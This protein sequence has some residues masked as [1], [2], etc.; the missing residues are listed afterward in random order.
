MKCSVVRE[1]ARVLGCSISFLVED[2]RQLIEYI[3]IIQVYKRLKSDCI[4]KVAY[5]QLKILSKIEGDA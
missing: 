3:E 4:R 5:E 1:L 2:E